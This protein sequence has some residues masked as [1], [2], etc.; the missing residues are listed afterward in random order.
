MKNQQI[1]YFLA[2]VTLGV[3][4]LIHGLVRLPKLKEFANGVIN[5]FKG[6]MLPEILVLPFAYAIPIVELILG[7]MLLLGFLTRKALIASAIL[8]IFLIAGSAL[9]EDWG[10][11]GTQMVYALYIFFLMF[12]FDY[13]KWSLSR[14]IFRS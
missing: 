7:I 11:V 6:T 4:F 1:A 12:Y 5:G 14:R 9:K 10:V 13:D 8:M 2:R 3:N